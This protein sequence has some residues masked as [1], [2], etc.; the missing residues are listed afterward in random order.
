MYK[1]Y[2]I[3]L[4]K[5]NKTKTLVRLAAVAVASMAGLYGLLHLSSGDHVRRGLLGLQSGLPL[6][7]NLPCI[8]AGC[9]FVL[10]L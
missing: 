6:T 3:L 4:T 8:S 2:I 9:P 7:S 10:L 5:K 1:T